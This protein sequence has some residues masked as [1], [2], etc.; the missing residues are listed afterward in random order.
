MHFHKWGFLHDL[1]LMFCIGVLTQA[2][3][4]S[5]SSRPFIFNHANNIWWKVQLIE[6]FI[7]KLSLSYI[8]YMSS[9]VCPDIFLS[10]LFSDTRQLN[11]LQRTVKLTVEYYISFYH[12]GVKINDC[13]SA[14]RFNFPH[15]LNFPNVYMFA[16]CMYVGVCIGCSRIKSLHCSFV[17]YL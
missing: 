6:L 12:E 17:L 4:M 2:C 9:V 10:T 3:Y 1:R 15:P 8:Q 7:V 14:G 13:L 5:L 16:Y 11:T